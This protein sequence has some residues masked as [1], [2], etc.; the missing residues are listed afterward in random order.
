MTR[1]AIDRAVD[2]ARERGMHQHDGEIRPFATWLN[3]RWPHHV[4]EIGALHGGTTHLWGAIATGKVVSIDLPNGTFGG[5]HHGYDRARCEARNA[6]LAR[7]MPGRF[8]G[9]LDD[10]HLESAFVQAR[11]A[12]DG[13]HADLLFIDGDH[14]LEDV[15]ADFEV[16]RRLVRP[17]GAI[18]FH[19]INDTPLHR[20]A[21]CVVS[22]FWQR[23]QGHETREFNIHADWGGIGVLRA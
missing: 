19:D 7:V 6:D 14:T 5:Q 17:G 9:V 22:D 13:Q 8:F 18:A 16:Y 2:V 4:I 11:W 15:T 3:E 23:F 1:D 20:A 10:S 21:G 12:L